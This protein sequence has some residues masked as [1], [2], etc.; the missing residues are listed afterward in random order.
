MENFI[1][2]LQETIKKCWNQPIVEDTRKESE[3]FGELAAK[4]AILNISLQRAGLNPGDKIAIRAKGSSNF[5]GTFLGAMC[6]GYVNVLMTSDLSAQETT[7]LVNKSDCRILFT[8]EDSF[9]N[10]N[11]DN[12]PRLIGVID[13]HTMKCLGGTD[14]FI[15]AFCNKNN[16]YKATYPKGIKPRKV[17]YPIRESE[18][19]CTIIYSQDNQKLPVKEVYRIGNFS[20]NFESIKDKFPFN[21][22]SKLPSIKVPASQIAFD[23]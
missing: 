15:D 22:I 8:D 12:M 2:R 13:I 18:D 7:E 4:I 6:G 23:I 17:Y 3:T 20:D 1:Y 9:R 16:Y 19:I 5:L 21:I 10:I 14:E 11:P